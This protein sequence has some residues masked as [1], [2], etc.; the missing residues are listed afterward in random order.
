MLLRCHLMR[1]SCNR[2][3]PTPRSVGCAFGAR[4]N[5]SSTALNALPNLTNR[6]QGSTAW[7]RAQCVVPEKLPPTARA[8][9]KAQCDLL[10]PQKTQR[11]QPAYLAYMGPVT[12]TST[13]FPRIHSRSLS[14]GSSANCSLHLLELMTSTES[15]KNTR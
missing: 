8:R 5:T 12:Y 9:R 10:A 3:T 11:V 13:W 7:R 4:Q 2:C 6:M 1:E 14:D 15:P